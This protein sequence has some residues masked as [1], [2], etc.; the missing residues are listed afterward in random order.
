[1]LAGFLKILLKHQSITGFGTL[2]YTKKYSKYRVF[3]KQLYNFERVVLQE[4]LHLKVYKL[5]IVQHLKDEDKVVHKE[6]CMQMF[7]QI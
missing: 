5:S 6:F 4:C 1:M 2:H 7:H 3:Q